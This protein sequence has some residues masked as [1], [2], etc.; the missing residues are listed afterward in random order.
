MSCGV[1]TD[2]N[3]HRYMHDQFGADDAFTPSDYDKVVEVVESIDV[4]ENGW[5]CGYCTVVNG[6]DAENCEVCEEHRTA[7]ATRV[8]YKL[9]SEQ[10]L[11]K[12]LR[13]KY[14]K[15]EDAL[16]RLQL[17]EVLHLNRGLQDELH[18]FHSIRD[19]RKLQR[20]SLH[21]ELRGELLGKAL[22]AWAF[23][24][25]GQQHIWRASDGTAK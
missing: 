18:N 13:T 9:K 8:V 7:T 14:R 1:T 15:E 2:L 10:E 24:D 20:M 21:E 4:G 6:S 17:N 5:R 25:E 12:S 11:K 3:V 22:L 16:R 19:K 23:S